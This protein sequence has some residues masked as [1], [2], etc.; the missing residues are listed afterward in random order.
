MPGLDGVGKQVL[1]PRYYWAEAFWRWPIFE[2]S[3]MPVKATGAGG[4]RATGLSAA[5]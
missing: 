5:P 1:G 3:N 4:R 2:G